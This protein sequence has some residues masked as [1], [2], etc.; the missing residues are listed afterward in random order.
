MTNTKKGGSSVS[1]VKTGIISSL[2]Q[3]IHYYEEL[4][5]EVI[6]LPIA[7]ERGMWC[8]NMSI[9]LMQNMLVYS[10]VIF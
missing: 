5:R 9:I 4:Q 7:I 8:S 10:Q 1:V 2:Q 6:E 3:S